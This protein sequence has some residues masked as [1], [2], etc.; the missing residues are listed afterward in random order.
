MAV[1]SAVYLPVWRATAWAC[2]RLDQVYTSGLI[3]MR[4]MLAMTALISPAAPVLLHAFVSWLQSTGDGCTQASS[5]LHAAQR[6]TCPDNC[7]FIRELQE[8]VTRQWLKHP[9][10][11]CRSPFPQNRQILA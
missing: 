3:P 4:R 8:N 2:T 1:G 5:M 6:P 10:Q 11:S 7:K 9:G